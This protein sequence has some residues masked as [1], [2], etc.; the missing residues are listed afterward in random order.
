MPN[1]LVIE[2][3]VFSVEEEIRAAGAKDVST[4]SA[5]MPATYDGDEFLWAMLAFGL[6]F[7]LDP[8]LLRTYLGA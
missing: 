5:M 3:K 2:I 8:V 4:E 6:V 1:V 7:V